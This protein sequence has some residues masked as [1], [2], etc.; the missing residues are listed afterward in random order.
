MP[1]IKTN[2]TERLGLWYFKRISSA[3][4]GEYD[5]NGA[6]YLSDDERKNIRRIVNKSVFNA[7]V[8]GIASSFISFLYLF[9]IRTEVVT[10]SDFLA[11]KNLVYL[12][13]YIGLT[14]ILSLI[15][16]IVL[17]FDTMHSSLKLVQSV[18]QEL[19][20]KDDTEKNFALTVSRAA[21]EIPNPRLSEINIDP[22]KDSNKFRRIIL[23]L[24]YKAKASITKL[25]FK[26]IVQRAIGKTLSRAYFAVLAIP[27]VG[28]WN[29]Y[30]AWRTIV[31]VKIRVL[32]P[33]TVTDILD[34]YKYQNISYKGQLQ[35]IRA[36]TISIIVA[37]DLHPNLELLYKGLVSSSEVNIRNSNI[38]NRELFI[39]RFAELSE[40]EKKYALEIMEYSIMLTGRTNYRKKVFLKRAYQVC[41]LDFDEA[42][43]RKMMKNFK[44][45]KSLVV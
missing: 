25:F 38:N 16:M 21:L 20:K 7:G 13:Q 4:Q 28:F 2:L 39:E 44:Q 11:D 1:Q 18:N 14:L 34:F 3:H 5:E 26:Y 27:V 43:F 35:M 12:F 37:E 6:L 32:G 17:F 15:E 33:S 41:N 10:I 36:V 30:E 45:G 29:S 22:L 19:F 31:E 24:I 8:I 40:I 23:I 42:K 9:N